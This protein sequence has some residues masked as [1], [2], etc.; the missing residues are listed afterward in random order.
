MWP[1]SFIQRGSN[2]KF[3]RNLRGTRLLRRNTR[4]Y[5][6]LAPLC[7]S[8]D[9]RYT[10]YD[11]LVIPRIPNKLRMR[12][13]WL[14]EHRRRRRRDV[15]IYIYHID[16]ASLNRLRSNW[17]CPGVLPRQLSVISDAAC[18]CL[19]LCDSCY[20]TTLL[21]CPPHLLPSFCLIQWQTHSNVMHLYN[22]IQQYVSV[23]FLSEVGHNIIGWRSRTRK[24]VFFVYFLLSSRNGP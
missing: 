18:V 15:D 3:E 4:L 7:V 9:G 20:N 10:A 6:H 19:L 2:V 12:L 1:I 13:I 23:F 14:F 17:T 5:R 8:L 16:P 21:N 24:K 11:P 22:D